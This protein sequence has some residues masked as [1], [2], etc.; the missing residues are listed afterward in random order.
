MRLHA[1]CENYNISESKNLGN[2]TK[3]DKLPQHDILVGGVPCQSWSIAGKNLG[4]KDDRGQLWND[5]IYLLNQAKPKAFI[6]ENVKGLTDPR[7]KNSLDYIMDRI[8]KAGYFANYYLLNS[9]DFGVLQARV[10]VYIIGFRKEE[11]YLK[12]K[13]ANPTPSRK[14]L[15]EVLDGLEKPTNKHDKLIPKDLFGNFIPLNQTRLQ[16]SD[17][18]NDFFVLSDIRNGHSTIHSWDILETTEREKYICLL[19]LKNRRKKQYGGLDGNPLSFKH[20]NNLDQS[21]SEQELQTLVGKGIFKEVNYIFEIKKGVSFTEKEQAIIDF[22]KKGIIRLDVVKKARSLS[23]KKINPKV[24][25]ADL[26]EQG[27]I[28]CIQKRYE[29]KFTKISSGIFGVNRVY[30]PTSDIYQRW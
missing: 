29:F 10:R 24:M 5:T 19:L 11:H 20:L 4:F 14:K 3:I 2:I 27:K 25:L 8:K 30:L 6:F 26:E 7:N 16:K 28:S 17:G 15:Y 21:I 12:F 22:A 13:I 9:Y 18:L 23:L 1:Y